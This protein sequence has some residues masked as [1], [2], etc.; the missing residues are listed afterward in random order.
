MRR[1]LVK[2][3]FSRQTFE[4]SVNQVMCL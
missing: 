1:D 2:N 3:I 4:L